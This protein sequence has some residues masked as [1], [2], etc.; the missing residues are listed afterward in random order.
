MVK[1]SCILQRGNYVRTLSEGLTTERE[2]FE[3]SADTVGGETF[4][5][6]SEAV[7]QLSCLFLYSWKVRNYRQ[8]VSMCVGFG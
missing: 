2:D 7:L 6:L 8:I 4:L 1:V 3:P 5:Q